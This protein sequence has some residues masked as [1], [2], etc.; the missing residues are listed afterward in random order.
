MAASVANLRLL[1]LLTA[2]SRTPAFLL[3]LTDPV[4]RSRPYLRRGRDVNNILIND[5]STSANF[6]VNT[7]LAG[8]NSKLHQKHIEAFSITKY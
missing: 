2:G 6:P 3:S 7:L 4:N 1:I 5:K 8:G